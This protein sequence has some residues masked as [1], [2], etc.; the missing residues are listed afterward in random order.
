MNDGN[1]PYVALGSRLR[2]APEVHTL[3]VKSNYHDYTPYEGMLI[4][5]TGV[6]PVLE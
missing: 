6:I 2:G 3:G 1:T 5:N 4:S